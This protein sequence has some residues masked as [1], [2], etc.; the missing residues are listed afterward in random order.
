MTFEGRK[1]K[2]SELFDELLSIS[3]RYRT[4]L[5]I[6][7]ASGGSKELTIQQWNNLQGHATTIANQLGFKGTTDIGERPLGSKASPDHADTEEVIPLKAE[8][9]G[10]TVPSELRSNNKAEP[11][12]LDEVQ[13][14]IEQN[15]IVGLDRPDLREAAISGMIEKLDEHSDYINQAE[16][17]AL[18]EQASPEAQWR[19]YRNGIR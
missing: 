10:Q 3:E 4:V 6:V 16:L 19:R 5:E 12:S 18:K 7:R 14:L 11:A 17:S 15:C 8:P 9:L 2:E 1:V 13:E